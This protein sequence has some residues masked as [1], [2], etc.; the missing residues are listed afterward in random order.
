MLD[1]RQAATDLVRH[2]LDRGHRHIG[3]IVGPQDHQD[4][5][6]RLQGYQDALRERGLPFV[7][8]FTVN[9]DFRDTSGLIGTQLLLS[10]HPEITA[11]FSS[12]DQ[13]A[14][15]ARLALHRLGLRVP[16]DISLVG[17]DDLPAVAYM[18]PP[19]TTVRQPM[20]EIGEWLAHFIVARLHDL[21]V[22]PLNVKLELQLR[23]SV[24]FRRPS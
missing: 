2:L 11:I 24:S 23:E 21:E 10:R 13:M 4:A 9:G 19:L 6:E 12:N 14:F 7:E 22:V 3:M 8:T 17:F 18:T 16:E 15:G 5:R 1:N 20:A